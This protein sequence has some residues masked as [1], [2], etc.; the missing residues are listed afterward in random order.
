MEFELVN[1]LA[2]LVDSPNTSSSFARFRYV[3][4]GAPICDRDGSKS[5]RCQFSGQ[6]QEPRTR[7]YENRKA[8]RVR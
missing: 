4:L 2:P 3:L 5:R 7:C 1:L 8:L 6:I